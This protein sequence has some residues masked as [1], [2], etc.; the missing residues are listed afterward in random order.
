MDIA[1]QLY[2]LARSRK[3]EE[4]AVFFPLQKQH[5][6]QRTWGEEKQTQMDI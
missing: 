4:L 6:G 1:S 2:F 3:L 5:G